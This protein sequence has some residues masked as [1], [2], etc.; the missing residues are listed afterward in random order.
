[1]PTTNPYLI[2]DGNCGEAMR[3]YA[4]VLHG[5]LDLMSFK[6]APLPPEQRK[7]E[8]E[9]RVI[10]ARLEVPGGASILASDSMAGMQYDGMTNV[11]ISL[12]YDDAG[13][14]KQI[15]DKMAEGGQVLMPFGKTFWSPGFGMC[16][17][18]FGANWMLNTES[19]QH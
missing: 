19:Q 15:F 13:E 11:F 17:D 9:H 8:D 2:F 10:H 5:K 14:A 1:M 12:T 16:T 3:F 18:R 4:D 6:D 7:P